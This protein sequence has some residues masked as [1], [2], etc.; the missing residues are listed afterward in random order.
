MLSQVYYGVPNVACLSL[1]P[2]LRNIW[3]PIVDLLCFARGG[4]D[5]N[6]SLLIFKSDFFAF[7]LHRRTLMLHKKINIVL[8]Q[9]DVYVLL[10]YIKYDFWS[11]FSIITATSALV[12]FFFI[13]R[14]SL[15]ASNTIS[16]FR[17]E[18][19]L[20]FAYSATFAASV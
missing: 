11:N 19:M 3:H 9:N 8:N 13:S 16:A 6:Q 17:Q 18:A 2:V 10:A 20:A 12:I 4:K 15:F 5:K 1:R 14:V 7:L